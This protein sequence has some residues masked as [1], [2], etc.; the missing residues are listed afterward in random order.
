MIIGLSGY[1]RSGK[2]TV[3]TMIQDLTAVNNISPWVVKRFAGKLKLVASI[4]TGVDAEKFEYQSFKDEELG[5][6]WNTWAYKGRNEGTHVLPHFTGEPYLKRMTVREFLQRLG[7][8]AV[9][10]GLH[11]NA[12]VNALMADYRPSK[13]SEYNPSK[14]IITD[15]RFENEAKAIKDR[16]GVVIRINRT[17]I[18]PVNSHISETALNGW[19]FDYIIE[20]NGT[21]QDLKSTVKILLERI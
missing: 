20:N 1:A 17:G 8:D 15:V 10:N 18:G 7:T 13:M 16:G 11:D 2:D 21:V 19:D 14:W 6:E 9:R 5:E 12:W 3:A 4:L